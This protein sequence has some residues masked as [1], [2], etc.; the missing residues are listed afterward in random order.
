V[1][2]CASSDRRSW[3]RDSHALI[4][5]RASAYLPDRTR[6]VATGN[7]NLG[8]LRKQVVQR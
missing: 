3:P 7:T 5:P 2:A 6:V 8:N 1:V 4:K